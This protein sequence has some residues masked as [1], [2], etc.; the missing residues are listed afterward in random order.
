MNIFRK[1]VYRNE[2]PVF[3]YNSDPIGNRVIVQ[4]T[5]RCPVCNEK[6]EYVYEG[7]FYSI[8]EVEN[9]CPWCIKNGN[10]AKKYDGEFQDPASCEEVD[11]SEY[12]DE[13]VHRTPGYMGWQQEVWLSHCGDFC[14]YIGNVG[15]KE[16]EHMNDELEDDLNEIMKNYRLTKDD[17][18]K[19]LVN[20]GS[21]Q[22][23][24]FKC[25]VCGK[26]RITSDCD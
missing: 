6:T 22:G 1:K 14:T 4:R 5:A 8:E 20:N 24:L 3:K 25:V 2:F 15:W 13:L 11:K 9:I 17:L 12:L 26:Y 18:K 7:P 19:F 16:I 21:L 10:A 23:Y